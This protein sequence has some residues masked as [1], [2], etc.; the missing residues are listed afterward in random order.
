VLDLSKLASGAVHWQVGDVDL[1][2]VARESANACAQLFEQRGATLD[3]SVP[4]HVP[5]V[6]L[7]ADRMKQVVINLLSNAAKFC[8]PNGHAS[9]TVSIERSMIRVDVTDDGEGIPPGD[10]Q[11]IFERFQ[12]VRG[13]DGVPRQGTGLGLPISTEIVRHFGGRLWVESTPGGGATFSFTVPMRPVYA[14]G[15]MQSR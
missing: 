12:Q 9:I 14:G 11:R 10:Q 5:S 15:R 6:P 3:V 4:P 8:R 13:P 7:D 2:A 1:A